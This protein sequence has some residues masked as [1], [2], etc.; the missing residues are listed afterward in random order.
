MSNKNKQKLFLEAHRK[1]MFT[2]TSY[3]ERNTNIYS[4]ELL[5]KTLPADKKPFLYFITPENLFSILEE[6][7]I[8]LPQNIPQSFIIENENAGIVRKYLGKH[9]IDLKSVL[10]ENYKEFLEGDI[11]RETAHVYFEL[12]GADLIL[13]L[14]KEGK[15][16]ADILLSGIEQGY[17]STNVLK[18][19]NINNRCVY[20]SC[21]LLDSLIDKTTGRLFQEINERDF[22][23]YFNEYND[24][25]NFIKV[26]SPEEINMIDESEETVLFHL[27]RE[28]DNAPLINIMESFI[29]KGGNLLHK[30][31]NG[32][33]FF[34][35][36]SFD[37]IFWAEFI[38]NDYIKNMDADFFQ[39]IYEALDKEDCEDNNLTE[40]Q[41]RYLLTS[42]QKI[43]L[44]SVLE[45]SNE[46]KINMSRL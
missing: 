34:E 7:C 35:D 22:S 44:E 36:I 11:P 14:V 39:K 24:L 15:L 5:I 9:L 42:L 40:E 29:N 27:F 1:F 13:N 28:S 8:G 10:T 45:K 33:Y 12:Y 21:R 4:L 38:N 46:N 2:Y 30:S 26:A 41:K 20:T 16:K 43:K 3:K 23:F 32:C 17:Y 37:A 25:L 19:K 6:N 31:E 18:E